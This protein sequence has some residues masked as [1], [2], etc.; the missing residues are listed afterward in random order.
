MNLR[1]IG[2]CSHPH[3]RA[4]DTFC[5]EDSTAGNPGWT[6]VSWCEYGHVVMLRL[7]FNN[8]SQRETVGN[9]SDSKW[10]E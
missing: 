5:L 9:F 7:S 6:A 1:K 2:P 10:C 8:E 3:C 4:Q